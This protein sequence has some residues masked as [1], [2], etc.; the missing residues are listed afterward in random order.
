[1]TPR[2]MTAKGSGLASGQP[3][4]IGHVQHDRAMSKREAYEP[5]EY[6][7]VVKSRG[8]AR[9]HTGVLRGARG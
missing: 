1:M 7:L 9:H 6:K 4:Y 8:G 5:G 2:F 3:Y